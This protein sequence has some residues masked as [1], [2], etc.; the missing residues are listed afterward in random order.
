MSNFGEIKMMS[1]DSHV[2]DDY[3]EHDHVKIGGGG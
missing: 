3:G 2:N 1:T